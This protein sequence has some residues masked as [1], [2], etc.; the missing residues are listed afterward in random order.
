MS[1]RMVGKAVCVADV[2]CDH[3]HT[4][5]KLLKDGIAEKCIAMDVRPG[6]LEKARE[7]LKLYGCL[8]KVEL[9]LSDGF[10]AL[11]PKEADI[12]II[13]GMGGVVMKDILERGL[14]T[15]GH[16]R[17][18]KPILILQPQSHIYEIRKWLCDNGYAITDEEMCFEDGKYYFAIKAEPVEMQLTS[19]SAVEQF[20][21]DAVIREAGLHFGPVLIKKKNSLM[22]QYLDYSYNKT[23]RKL[24]QVKMSDSADA[25]EKKEYFQ[26]IIEILEKIR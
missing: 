15:D 16:L 25:K 18:C 3:A 19:G 11:R 10:D 2:G 5:I 17:D 8:E 23:V 9:R 26:S 24:G 21:E 12:C 7:N 13:A 14:G 20:L 22:K 6:P 1:L 4:D